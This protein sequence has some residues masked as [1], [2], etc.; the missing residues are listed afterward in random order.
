MT[1]PS[2][3]L[4]LY[5]DETLLDELADRK[6]SVH[7]LTLDVAMDY[8][9]SQGCPDEILAA[10]DEWQSDPVVGP[11]HLAVWRESAAS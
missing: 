5:S 11:R 8:L 10:L 2:R 6:L 3:H 4:K 1:I 7:V 9:A